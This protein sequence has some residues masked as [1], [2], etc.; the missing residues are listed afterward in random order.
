[1][2]FVQKMQGL[3]CNLQ[4]RGTAGRQDLQDCP[5]T[6]SLCSAPSLNG[7]SQLLASPSAFSSGFLCLSTARPGC[8]TLLPF[9]FILT[10]FL[11]LLCHIPVCD[12]Q[13]SQLGSGDY[14]H[15]V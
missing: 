4:T 13:M 11:L 2:G 6:C 12:D 5:G 10:Q 1:M 8:S 14:S 9:Q 15:R 7:L 3:S